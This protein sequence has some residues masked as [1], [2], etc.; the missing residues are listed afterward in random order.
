MLLATHQGN[1]AAACALD[2]SK[3][4]LYYDTFALRDFDGHET[5]SQIWPY[6]R[7]RSSRL[8]LQHGQPV[9]VRSCWNGIGKVDSI[10][11]FSK[12]CMLSNSRHGFCPLLRRIAFSRYS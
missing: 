2:F 5:A 6:F 1:Y 4:P 9:P 8:A 3:P 10:F 7:A 11:T 12:L